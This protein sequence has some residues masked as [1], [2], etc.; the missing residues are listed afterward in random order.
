MACGGGGGSDDLI[1]SMVPSVQGSGFSCFPLWLHGGGDRALVWLAPRLPVSSLG[2]PLQGQLAVIS[3]GNGRRCACVVLTKA[4]ESFQWFW[5]RTC[6]HVRSSHCW[7]FKQPRNAPTAVTL[8]T[9]LCAGFPPERGVLEAQW[10]R[11]SLHPSLV[12][13]G[14]QQAVCAALNLCSC[15]SLLG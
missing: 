10:Q 2:C 7:H 3:C 15:L 12:W 5:G 6:S 11:V 9:R 8:E 4:G 14:S 13:L 1:V